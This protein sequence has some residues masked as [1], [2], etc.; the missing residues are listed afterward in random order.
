MNLNEV[1]LTAKEVLRD[2]GNG[3]LEWSY[4]LAPVKDQSKARKVY[5]NCKLNGNP[6]SL[7]IELNTMKIIKV[8]GRDNGIDVVFVVD[9][10]DSD[11]KENLDVVK[12][13]HDSY[14][15][16]FGENSKEV[17]GRKINTKNKELYDDFVKDNVSC[18]YAQ[19]KK[20]PEKYY[21]TLKIGLDWSTRKFGD[22]NDTF[23]TSLDLK[24]YKVENGE[25]NRKPMD[26]TM[27][28]FNDFI[29][30]NITS[31]VFMQFKR[32]SVF[33]K[34]RTKPGLM[35]THMRVDNVGNRLAE[36]PFKNTP[37]E[38]K[39]EDMPETVV[40]NNNTVVLD[41]EE[42]S[43]SEESE[44]EESK[45]EKKDESKDGEDKS[46][47]EVSASD[48]SEDELEEVA[49]APKKKVQSKKVTKKSK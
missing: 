45:D 19:G 42:S 14:L 46:D 12:A 48:S 43:D 24:Y 28:N 49:P 17:I 4:K 16:W 38:V 7:F 32:A 39:V 5:V 2:L 3:K 22:D 15:E 30:Y 36:Y 6:T 9:V 47:F 26:V 11:E 34:T 27:N 13:I 31:H 1:S 41:N 18:L 33:Q 25:V 37:S 10:N 21:I 35:I 40:E 23:P 44:K 20:N 29:K 8:E